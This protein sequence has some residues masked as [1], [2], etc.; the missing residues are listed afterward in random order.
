LTPILQ[1][2]QSDENQDEAIQTPEAVPMPQDE[3]VPHTD[4]VEAQMQ[5]FETVAQTESRPV[6][7]SDDVASESPTVFL[8]DDDAAEHQ[9]HLREEDPEPVPSTQSPRRSL[10]GKAATLTRSLTKFMGTIMFQVLDIM[11]IFSIPF[12]F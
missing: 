11:L 7:K 3:G 2:D 9:P 6:A 8:Q 5:E 12:Q 10:F 4:K 1:T